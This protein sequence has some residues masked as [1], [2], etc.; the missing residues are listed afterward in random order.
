MKDHWCAGKF[1]GEASAT[2]SGSDPTFTSSSNICDP[3]GV[4]PVT[5]W[6]Q[7]PKGSQILARRALNGALC[8]S[9]LKGSQT[10]I[11]QPSGM[12]P[13]VSRPALFPDGVAV[14]VVGAVFPGH[15]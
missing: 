6:D 1:Y 12:P 8:I 7:T 15:H 9:T 4:W 11:S 14:Q 2:P 13:L 5:T 3:F 10:V